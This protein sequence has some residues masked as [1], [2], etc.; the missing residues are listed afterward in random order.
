MVN[1]VLKQ[2]KRV[3]KPC[4]LTD[5]GMEVAIENYLTHLCMFN[6]VSY[7][8]RIAYWVNLGYS[9]YYSSRLMVKAHKLLK[10]HIA[11]INNNREYLTKSLYEYF[12]K[13]RGEKKAK[14]FPLICK[15]NG[16]IKEDD[17]E[18]KMIQ[19][20]IER[21]HQKQHNLNANNN[22]TAAIPP[23]PKAVSTIPM[24]ISPH[25]IRF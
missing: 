22:R 8:D 4:K 1:N 25:T 15:M 11:D 23:T 5:W 14:L 6:K 2:A 17:I 24:N 12:D 18:L 20:R 19:Y 9:K 10:Q 16:W 7:Q 21:I 3:G 13:L